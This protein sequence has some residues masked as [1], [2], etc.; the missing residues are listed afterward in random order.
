MGERA[1]LPAQSLCFSC[2][3]TTNNN[4][5]QFPSALA[6]SSS[7]DNAISLGDSPFDLHSFEKKKSNKWIR[8]REQ[9]GNR[10]PLVADL[11]RVGSQPVFNSAIG[12]QRA[13]VQAN[14]SSTYRGTASSFRYVSPSPSSSQTGAYAEVWFHGLLAELLN[15]QA[16]A[17]SALVC[18]IISLGRQCK[19][20]RMLLI[21]YLMQWWAESDLQNQLEVLV[22]T[23]QTVLCEESV[24]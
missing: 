8:W 7:F 10:P 1:D 19:S 5:S 13:N 12:R 23:S 9:V 3:R 18:S 14:A 22:A 11:P 21:A 4:F 6:L 20:R 16:A 15:R 24:D 17:S 2:R